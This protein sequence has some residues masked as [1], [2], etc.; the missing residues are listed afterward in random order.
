MHKEMI[1]HTNQLQK[2]TQIQNKSS[3]KVAEVK[4]SFGTE[5]HQWIAL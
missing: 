1:T 2:F 4:I 3:L 5:F